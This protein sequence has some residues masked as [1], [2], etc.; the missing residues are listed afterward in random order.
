VFDSIY[1]G[2]SGLMSYSKGL[3]SIGNNVANL[4]TAGF[5]GSDLEFLDVKC[6]IY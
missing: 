2:M 4:N 6:T 1:T 3:S 5:K